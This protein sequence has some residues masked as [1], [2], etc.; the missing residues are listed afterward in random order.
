MQITFVSNPLC[1]K[2]EMGF[3]PESPDRLK[4]ALELAKE[5][6]E[7]GKAELIEAE[8]ATR[9]DILLVHEPELYELIKKVS[10]RGGGYLTPDNRANKYTFE[11]SLAAAGCTIKAAMLSLDRRR[12]SFSLCRPPGHHASFSRPAGFCFFNNIA[13]SA[14]KLLAASNTQ[15]QPLAEKI[16]IVDIDQHFGDGTSDIFYESNEVLYVSLHADPHFSYPGTGFLDE[17][18]S[19]DGEGFNVC[20]PLPPRCTDSEYLLV[21]DEIALPVVSEFAPDT[22]LVSAGFDGLFSDSVGHLSLTTFGYQTI[23]DRIHE[24]AE[25]LKANIASSLEGGY[26][27]AKF[28]D[29]IK[30][31]IAFYEPKCRLQGNLGNK[32]T[33]TTIKKTITYLKDILSPFWSL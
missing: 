2:H 30:G 3:H 8:K 24:T 31:H 25:H 7:A 10:E 20:I 13:I 26:D 17:I 15:D 19:G 6:S 33:L 21:L 27:V 23:A 22:I 29:C 12:F 32:S 18:G 11:A 14:A 28:K 9:D 5:L 16:A 1:L 4:T